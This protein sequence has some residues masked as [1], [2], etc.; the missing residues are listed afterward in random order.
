MA[1]LGGLVA[2]THDINTPVGIGVT[3][4]SFLQERLD[5]LEQAYN[6]KTLSPKALE[7][8]L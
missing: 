2:S 8:L 6:G 1:T 5:Q 3:A 4:T 7:G